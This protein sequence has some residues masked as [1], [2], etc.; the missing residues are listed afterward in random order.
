[1][2]T[3]DILIGTALIILGVVSILDGGITF[4]SL[5]LFGGFTLAMVT[6]LEPVKE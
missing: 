1:M 2:K 6:S 4:G 3:V 5:V